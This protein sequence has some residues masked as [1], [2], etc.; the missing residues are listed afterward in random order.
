MSFLRTL[1]TL[2]L[3]LPLSTAFGQG[4]HSVHQAHQQRYEKLGPKTEAEWDSLHGIEPMPARKGRACSLQ[5]VVY[6]WHPYWMG[7]AY[8]NYQWDLLSHFSYFSYEVDPNTGYPTTTNNWLSSSAV[9]AAQNNGVKADLCVTLFSSHSTFFSS[10]TARQNLIDTLISLVQARN[11]NGVNIDFEGVPSSEAT[12]YNNFLVNLATQMHNQIPG[13]EVS[14]ALYAVDW[15]NIF[16]VSLLDQYLDHMVIMGYGYYYNGSAEA[17][18]TAPLFDFGSSSWN[19]SRTVNYYLKEGASRSKLVLG[20]PY[21]GYEWETASDQ[22]PENTTSTGSSRTY[23]TVRDNASGNYSNSNKGWHSGS[24]SNYF[25]FKDG[26]GNWR[27]CFTDLAKG[28]DERLDLILQRDLAGMGIWALGYDDGYTA[29]WDE[30]EAHFTDCRTVPCSDT[31]YDQGG[32][33][34]SYNND[35]YYS[36]TIDP[37]AT[38][39]VE[40]NFLSFDIEFGYDSLWIYDGADTNAA[41]IGS[42]TGTSGPGK[43]V[44]SGEA[45]TLK[46]VSDGATVAPGWEAVWECIPDSI[47]PGTSLDTLPDWVTG[48]F[49]VKFSD[50]DE[51]GGSGIEKGFYSVQQW[52]NGEWRGNGKA[53]FFHDAFGQNSLHPDWTVDTG[54]WQLNGGELQQK[55][56]SLSNTNIHATLQQSLSNRYLYHWRMQM[57]G[58]GGNRRAGLH[59]FCDSAELSNRGNS[60][61]VWFRLDDD[62]IQLYKVVNNSWGSGPVHEVNYDFKDGKW[63]DLKL[64][65][66]RTDGRTRV[67]VNDTLEASWEDPSPHSTGN[68]IS[69]RS[70]N[71]ELHVEEL[72][73]FRSR[74]PT[75][76]VPVGSALS[77]H[78]RYQNQGPKQWGGRIAS[79]AT[80]SAGNISAIAKDS[81]KVDT[82]APILG[83]LLDGDGSS[84]KDTTYDP[85]GTLR[86]NWD[87]ADDPHSGIDHY[88]YSIGE[89]PGDSNLLG[90]TSTPDTSISASGLNLETDSTYFFNL[91]A[92]NRAGLMNG[93]ISDGIL[94]QRTTSIEEAKELTGGYVTPNPFRERFSLRWNKGISPERVHL[95]DAQG[96]KI[97]I[98]TTRSGQRTLRVLVAESIPSGVYF[99]WVELKDGHRSVF[100]LVR[101]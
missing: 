50:T 36:Y 67:Y 17:G 33:A 35:E 49:D 97:A 59:Y 54:T 3:L 19:L 70:G 21:Y 47:P 55:D 62:K 69:F 88:A 39:K 42:Y 48:D 4:H 87:S 75:V 78:L 53:G 81:V 24:M 22:V 77:D 13:S 18:P 82:T 85:N 71:A 15:N 30:I 5:R 84:D 26:S 40:L 95:F 45:L 92:F 12:A 68:A 23:T 6:G 93:K 79:I 100:E 96:R 60:Y 83:A 72:Q 101:Q 57:S 34:A 16:D 28:L 11:A 38:G 58:S 76:S 64:S 86:A 25:V 51:T 63:Y 61:F 91:R 74:Y 10:S 1:I 90:W 73:V 29:L 89:S 52:T 94:V 65:F 37:S 8:T 44:S 14:V 98:Q 31:L 2:L 56:E 43:I 9:T 46:F 80:D 27:Q 7:S 20:L 99:L 32:P 66:D 41:L